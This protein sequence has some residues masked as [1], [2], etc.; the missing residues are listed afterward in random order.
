MPLIASSFRKRSSPSHSGMS[1]DLN[2]YVKTIKTAT[3]MMTMTTMT[4]DTINSLWNNATGI[5]DFH[6]NLQFIY[7][8]FQKMSSR[9]WMQHLTDLP[10]NYDGNKN[11]NSFHEAL[12][13]NLPTRDRIKIS[14]MIKMMF[15]LAWMGK[16]SSIYLQHIKF[17]GN[18]VMIKR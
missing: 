5:T 1:K 17:G 9:S 2:R 15:W 3:T 7:I 10:S 4:T 8:H 12:N 18:K 11:L 14:L 13:S 6:F 16:T